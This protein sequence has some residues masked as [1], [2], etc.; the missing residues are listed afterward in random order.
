MRFALQALF[1]APET[2][3]EGAAR[4]AMVERRLR[5]N[6]RS[7]DFLRRLRG[8]VDDASLQAPE[9]FAEESF[10][11]A[12]VVAEYLDGQA[13][14]ELARAYEDVCRDSSEALAEVGRCY[15]ILNNDALNCVVV[16]K[17]CR[18]RL[19]YI[20]WED[21]AELASKEGKASILTNAMPFGAFGTDESEQELESKER[22]GE[23]VAVKANQ[24]EE[25][26]APSVGST[27][28]AERSLARRVRR[29]VSRTGL[30]LGLL[31]AIFACWQTL[32][33]D[34]GSETLNLKTPKSEEVAVSNATGGEKNDGET[35]LRPT[36]ISGVG[37]DELPTTAL[38]EPAN[39]AGEVAFD[40]FDALS[41]EAGT[42][43]L[44]TLPNISSD[45]EEETQGF[46]ETSNVERARVGLGN[47]TP[48]TRRPSIEIPAQ[49]NDVFSKMERF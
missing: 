30:A 48:W 21:G 35:P 33:D 18:R 26:S 5:S 17:N 24:S 47:E 7:A 40:D 39:V 46:A 37:V 6:E 22:D 19:Y 13:S 1:S 44:A 11:D 43:R 49:N 27:L 9:V 29:F 45:R 42:P 4:R 25:K 8:V 10:P 38:D 15:D 16:P 3:E 32:S 31:G 20:A 34:K 23:R 14:L 28:A 41:R 2:D 36:T 12:N